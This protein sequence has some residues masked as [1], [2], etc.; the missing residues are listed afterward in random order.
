MTTS[1][2]SKRSVVAWSFALTSLAL[3]LAPAC[4]RVDDGSPSDLAS[5]SGGTVGNLGGSSGGTESGGSDT[6]GAA[7]T[8][9]GA[10]GG[11]SGGRMPEQ[12]FEI[13]PYGVSCLEDRLQYGLNW[14]HSCPPDF[15]PPTY[16]TH[17]CALG[18]REEGRQLSVDFS[19]DPTDVLRRVY[20]FCEEFS[21]R[22]EG[23]PCTEDVDCLTPIGALYESNLA[24]GLGGI[25]GGG[26]A[27]GAADSTGGLLSC[28]S[29][30]KCEFREPSADGLGQ[31]CSGDT[32]GFLTGPALSR[33]AECESGGCLVLEGGEAGGLCTVGCETDADCSD[34]YTCSDVL[35]DRYTIWGATYPF[36]EPPRVLV[37]LPR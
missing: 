30:G 6:G 31:A 18:C 35:D 14:E 37:C 24:E 19:G 17:E 10:T 7:E 4:D 25:G 22:G 34:D 3:T 26:G 27:G 11:G 28:G 12:C 32:D 16:P 23:F 33:S 2:Y 13:M 21:I 8:G 36:V 9:S 1:Q 20:G 5:S 29:T 15:T